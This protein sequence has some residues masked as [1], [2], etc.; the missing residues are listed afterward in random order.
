MATQYLSLL[1]KQEAILKRL[2]S[3]NLSRTA[4]RR[5]AHKLSRLW[6]SEGLASAIGREWQI[7][8]Q[9]V[10]EGF[11]KF[12][13]K[14][15]AQRAASKSSNV[16]AKESP[17]SNPPP[18]PSGQ[19]PPFQFKVT[20]KK[21]MGGSSGGG[22]SGGSPN[23]MLIYL[24]AAGTIVV[25]YS[26]SSAFNYEEI[27]WKDF[28]SDYLTRG[29]VTKLE[30]VNKKWVRVVMASGSQTNSPSGSTVWFNIGSVESFERNLETAQNELHWD[31]SNS[32]PVI[33][34]DERSAEDYVFYAFNIALF[35]TVVYFFTKLPGS[36][37]KS[38]GMGGLFG[39]GRSTAKV[40]K[41]DVGVRFKD[42]AGCEEA[43]VEIMEFVNF[44]KNPKQYQDLGAKIPKGAILTG[45]PGTGKTLLAKATAGEAN[46]PFITA[47]GSEFLEMFVGVGPSRVRDMF[48]Q[49]R[50]NSPCIL[51]IDEIDAVGRKRGGKNFGGHSEQENTLN[52]MLVEMDGF[53]PQSNVVVLAAT[54]RVD[55]LDPALLR[56]GRFDRQI[57][58]ALPDIKGRASIF[59]VHLTPLK[60]NLN[61]DEVSRKMAALTP[62]FSGADIANVCNEAALIAARD[63]NESID[64]KHFE[65]AIERVLAGLE[66]KTQ[67]LQPEEKRTTAYHEAGHAVAGWYL[68][69]AD[70][71]LKVSIIPRGKGLGYAMYQ[72]KDQ[73]LYTK[74]QLFDRMC[75]TLGGRVAEELFFD[76]IT[77]GAQ[78]DLKKI[79]QSAYAQVAVLGMNDRVGN[80]SFDMPQQG[81]M[82]MTKPYSEQT[83]QMIDEEVRKLIKSAHTFTTELLKKHRPEV[84]KVAQLLLKEE[85]IDKEDM[86]ALLGARPF[87]E[88]TTYEEFVE[89]T[90]SFEEDTTLP[91]GLE[92]WN[93]SKEEEATTEGENKEEKS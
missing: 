42:V 51:F 13:G 33:Y 83:A 89:G 20:L 90:G 21:P 5:N 75:M 58:V 88:K 36:S 82:V 2:I 53:T 11:E 78:D 26:L 56:P 85:K 81:E 69:F 63:L 10:P 71:L 84:E 41:E 16:A 35:G 67:V 87:A 47:S 15:P 19:K 65:Q 86:L 59:K 12:Y 46:V 44:L 6:Q 29:V 49:A 22:A 79:T 60:T 92:N 23:P 45:P 61:K 25:L 68:E 55:I 27:T 8:R 39:F 66:K 64:T 93:K 14:K 74:E 32:I 48:A 17:K 28:V 73:F 3:S 70:P 1:S 52:Q 40:I 50:D 91:K 34:K 37:G 43:K 72:P 38:G 7:L 76:R 4:V 54:N 77:S 57:Y 80:V 9:K 62:G 24:A 31:A 30:V 18:P